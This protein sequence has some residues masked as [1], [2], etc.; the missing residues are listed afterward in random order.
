MNEMPDVERDPKTWMKSFL[1][2]L[3]CL[4]NKNVMEKDKVLY[5]FNY[6]IKTQTLGLN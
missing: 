2:N 4:V 5:I 6:R 1:A 3:K